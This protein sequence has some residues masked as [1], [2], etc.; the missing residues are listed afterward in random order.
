MFTKKVKI[1]LFIIGII[2]LLLIPISVWV[3]RGAKRPKIKTGMPNFYH[4]E[5]VR[6]KP[7]DPDTSVLDLEPVVPIEDMYD[8]LNLH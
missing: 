5:D 8:A 2:I 6:D 3:S 4:D 7:D 1:R